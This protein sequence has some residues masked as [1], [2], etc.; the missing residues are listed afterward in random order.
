M[1]LAPVL[2]YPEWLK[3]RRRRDRLILGGAIFAAIALPSLL[4]WLAVSW[5]LS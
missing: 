3:R 2:T 4:A 1:S 5:W